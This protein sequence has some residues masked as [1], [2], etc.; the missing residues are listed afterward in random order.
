MADL[1]PVSTPNTKV[2]TRAQLSQYSVNRPGWEAVRQS[3]YDF[4]S[5]PQAGSTF[6]AFFALPVGQSGKT[7]SDTNMSL[8]GQLPKNQEFLIQS[9][10]IL[11]FPSVPTVAASMPAAFGAPAV[12]ALVNDTYI[13]GRSG[14]LQLVIGSKPYL[15]EAPL[16]RFPPKTRMEIDAALSDATTAGA[17]LATRVAIAFWAG[18]PYILDPSPLLLPENQNFS[19]TLSWPEGAQAIANPARIGVVLDGILYRRSQ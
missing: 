4:Q 13:V 16:G 2:P 15:Q 14:N 8:A 11:L 19:L 17:N 10:E 12:P 18:R 9:V 3:L 6:L 7:L 1:V 5:Y